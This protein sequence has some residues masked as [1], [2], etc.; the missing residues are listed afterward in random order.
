ME[1]WIIFGEIFM[2]EQYS[3]MVNIEGNQDLT[4]SVLGHIR[5]HEDQK[6]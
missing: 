5:N 1:D 4:S 3:I 6:Y 2:G